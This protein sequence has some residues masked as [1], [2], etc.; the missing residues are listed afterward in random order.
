MGLSREVCLNLSQHAALKRLN[1]N[2]ELIQGPPATGKSTTIHALATECV[3][4][5]AAVL[6]CAVQ[7]RAI[8]ALVVKFEATSTSFITIGRSIVCRATYYTSPPWKSSSS[9]TYC[10]RL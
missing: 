8:E 3:E 6:I 7:N 2:I 5:E 1:S 4:L 9:V 10:L